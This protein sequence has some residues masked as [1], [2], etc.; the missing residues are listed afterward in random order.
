M[1]G[2]AREDRGR[3]K[4]ESDGEDERLEKIERE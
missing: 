2:K 4:V 3:G 1:G